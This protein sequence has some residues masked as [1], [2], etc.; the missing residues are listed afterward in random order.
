MTTMQIAF[1]KAA[2]YNQTTSNSRAIFNSL[3][4]RSKLQTKRSQELRVIKQHLFEIGLLK[5]TTTNIKLALLDSRY[6]IKP[7]MEFI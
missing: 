2:L 1:S 7:G 4:I 6:T 5:K 3:Q